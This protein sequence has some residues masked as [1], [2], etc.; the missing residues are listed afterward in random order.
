MK[1]KKENVQK[2]QMSTNVLILVMSLK[3]FPFL[4]FGND[5]MDQHHPVPDAQKQQQS[6]ALFIIREM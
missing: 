1:E 4:L 6:S 2:E 5:M 3:I